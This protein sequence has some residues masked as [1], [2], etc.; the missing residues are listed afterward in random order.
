MQNSGTGAKQG[1]PNPSQASLPPLILLTS[2]IAEPTGVARLDA[3]AANPESIEAAE[4]G[5]LPCPASVLGH[6][7]CRYVH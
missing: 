2:V 3:R 4:A 6:D 5:C 1:A 7:V